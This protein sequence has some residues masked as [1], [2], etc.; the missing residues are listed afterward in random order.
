M[1]SWSPPHGSQLTGGKVIERQVHGAAPAVARLRGH[2][3]VLDHLRPVDARVVPQFRPAIFWLFG[4]AD[5]AVDGALG[6]I[7]IPEKQPEATGGCLLV[8]LR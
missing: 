2:I 3:S 6:A 1:R 5:E 4:P 8:C 7:P